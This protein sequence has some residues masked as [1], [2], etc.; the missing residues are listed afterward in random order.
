M[1]YLII[2]L[3]SSALSDSRV[4]R[5]GDSI[6]DHPFTAL[7]GAFFVGYLIYDYLKSRK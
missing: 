2:I 4:D 3:Q 1:N 6:W 5:G 7:I